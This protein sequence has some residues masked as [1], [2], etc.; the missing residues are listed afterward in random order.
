M[1]KETIMQ[2]YKL[3][4]MEQKFADLIWEKAPVASG[5]LVKLCGGGF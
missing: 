3:G 4:E 1:E 2:Q 5:E